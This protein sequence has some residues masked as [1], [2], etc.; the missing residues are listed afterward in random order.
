MSKIPRI[1]SAYY[2]HGDQ[3]GFVVCKYKIYDFM[4]KNQLIVHHDA[5]WSYNSKLKVWNI[6]WPKTKPPPIINY[7]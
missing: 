5:L 6:I 1:I 7:N 4:I 3:L 2:G